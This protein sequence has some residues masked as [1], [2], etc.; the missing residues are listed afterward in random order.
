M[1]PKP[2]AP[3]FGFV[4]AADTKAADISAAEVTDVQV[5]EETPEAV[6]LVLAEPAAPVVSAPSRRT[7]P[8]SPRVA[9]PVSTP[10]PEVPPAVP[11]APV[12]EERRA[13][14]TRLR[15]SLKRSLDAFVMEL[16]MAGWSVSQEVVLESLVRRLRDDEAL[17]AGVTAELTGAGRGG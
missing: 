10:T 16:K 8:A 3:R 5:I 2:K 6:A 11:S 15:P 17:R 4:V 1:A 9:V 14:S 12:R 7:T 13:F